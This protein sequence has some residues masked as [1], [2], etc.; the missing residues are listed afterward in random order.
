MKR[1]P[2]DIKNHEILVLLP[3]F[4]HIS[5]NP[6]EPN[7]EWQFTCEKF[8][9]TIGK[10]ISLSCQ[11]IPQ[12]VQ[13]DKE[14]QDISDVYKATL[15]IW[16]NVR[17]SVVEVQYT[18][19]PRW[20]DER[21]L[22][23][24]VVS[25]TA[26]QLTLFIS[27]DGGD[28]EYVLNFMAGNLS[29]SLHKVD[30]YK[31]ALYF[32]NRALELLPKNRGVEMGQ[33]VL[34]GRIGLTLIELKRTDEGFANL[35][36]AVQLEPDSSVGFTNRCIGYVIMGKKD[37]ALAEC[38]KAIALN[39]NDIDAYEIR[40]GI[41]RDN[42]SYDLALKDANRAIEIS[43]TV[44]DFIVR[45]YVYSSKGD[46]DKA[47]LDCNQAIALQPDEAWL[48]A[49]RGN[50]YVELNQSDLAL[51][52]LNKAL[53]I[54]NKRA[55]AYGIRGQVFYFMKKYPEAINDL[56][57]AIELEQGD[58]KR[59]PLEYIN[60]ARAFF[61]FGEYTL[62]ILDFDVTIEIAEENFGYTNIS[63][64]NRLIPDAYNGRAEAY[65]KLGQ[66][67]NALDSL[68]PYLTKVSN[69]SADIIRLVD[70]LKKK[71]GITP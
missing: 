42:G 49:A 19:S 56:T 66:Y 4:I 68:Q 54:D 26:E 44:G 15:V 10:E 64:S 35:D 51:N 16:G 2:A 46:Y 8:K 12:E 70:T 6:L 65:V 38:N 58:I 33:T 25:G 57:K 14:A 41:Y 62:A 40:S 71:L 11:V 18:F 55:D 39:P 9:K 32:F 30:S 63:A 20:I 59:D 45:A 43:G 3:K 27:R 53:E 69:P 13:S 31:R 37:V 34:L 52:D 48:Y 24:T 36:K 61:F 22:P 67:Q 28:T 21:F 50:L 1:P 7:E 17:G 47:I 5:G 29:Q 60:R 23:H